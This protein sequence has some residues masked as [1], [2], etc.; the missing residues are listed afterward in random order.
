MEKKLLTMA[1][2]AKQLQMPESTV[3][4]YRD[5][6]IDYIPYVGNGR[7]RRYRPETADVLRFI[8]EGFNRNLTAMEIEQGLSLV[9]VS[10]LEIQEGTATR[11]AA[12]QQQSNS[13]E[14]SIR[15]E[16]GEEFREIMKQMRVA[17]QVIAQ[18]KE[19]IMG[20]RK[21]IAELRNQQTKQRGYGPAIRK[22]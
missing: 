20:L 18:Q 10:N 16:V 21:E 11:T 22:T 7:H 5:R 8:A 2:L 1:E 3:R 13:Q 14:I 4:Y 9:A 17:T 19:E 12:A 6:F 15:L